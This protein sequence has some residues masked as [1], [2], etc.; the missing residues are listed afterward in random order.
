MPPASTQGISSYA[1]TGFGLSLL[2]GTDYDRRKTKLKEELQLDYKQHI[3]KK[4]ELKTSKPHPQ[5]QGLSLPIKDKTSVQEKLREERNKE[6]NLFLKNQ[7]Q[8]RKFKRVVPPVTKEASD[9]VCISSP[10]SPLQIPNM[11]TNYHPP[12]WERPSSRKDAAT[13][14]EEVGNGKRTGAW[15][16]AQRGRRRWQIIKQR[17]SY[18]SE[19]ELDIDRE[20]ELVIRRIRRHSDTPELKYK[21]ERRAREH[22]ATRAPQGTQEVEASGGHDQ[23]NNAL[24]EKPDLEMP[25]RM[26]AA[27]RSRPATSWDKAE[28]ATG[29]IIGAAEEQTA[30]QLRKEQYKQELLKQ[31]AEQQRN[32]T[33]EK[34][35]QLG[36]AATGVTDPEKEPHR[37]KHFGSENLGYDSWK[38]HSSKQSGIDLKPAKKD[39]YPWTRD[40]IPTEDSEQHVPLGMSHVDQGTALRRLTGT[41]GPRSE[42]KAAQGVPSLDYF[43][44]N[45]HRDFSNILGEVAL[46]RVAAVPPPVTP[47][48][49]SQYK[50]PY[51]AAYY[52]YGAR[53]PLDPHL[54]YYQNGA[55]GGEQQRGNFHSPLQR[56]PPVRPSDCTRAPTPM[57]IGGVLAEKSN[58][59]RENALSY[60]EALRQQIKDREERRK[61]EKEEKERY[62]AKIEAES[63]AYNPWGR[64]GGGAPIKD[65][66]GNLISNL[67]QM[68]RTNKESQRNPVSRNGGHLH[69][70]LMRTVLS[71]GREDRETPPRQLSGFNEDGYREEL[72]KQ[73]EEKRQKQK[74]ESERLRLE[75]EKENK[76]LE[77]ERACIRL[78]YEE[79]QRKQK[80]VEHRLENQ[81]LIHEPKI[82]HKR[83]DRR[84]RQ[85]QEIEKKEPEIEKKEPEIEKNE[86]EIEKNEPE[87]EKKVREEREAAWSYKREPSPPIPTLQRKN[88]NPVPSR[89]PSVVSQLSSGTQPSVS[90]PD[91]REVPAKAPQLQ[92]GQQEVIREL[93]ALRRHL[94]NEQRQLEA[95]TNQTN[96]EKWP[97][98]SH[99]RP[100]GRARADAFEMS[101]RR[102]FQS[103]P[104]SPTPGTACANMQNIREFNQLKYRD[105]A[106]REDLCHMY[107]D[108][109]TDAHSLDIQ[110]QALLREQKRKIRLMGGEHVHDSLDQGMNF[111]H[112]NKPEQYIHRDDILPSQSVFTDVY[113]GGG[114][115]EEQIQK[116]RRQ[117]PAES[118]ERT[119]TRRRRDDIGVAD[120]IDQ[121][122]CQSARGT[123][124]NLEYGN[125]PCEQQHMPRQHTDTG[126]LSGDEADVLSLSSALGRPVSVGTVATEAWLRPG[127]SDAVKQRQ[128]SRM[129]T[130]PWLTK[131][132]T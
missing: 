14:T 62:D 81:S 34:K 82:Q 37:M 129:E 120:P 130:L 21:E 44:E 102:A 49:N 30:S 90:A 68:H 43:N 58:H 29:L 61:R 17:G 47:S 69:G 126:W 70:F 78:K 119:A 123:N 101:Q 66:N 104:R 72:R 111:Y 35:L 132:L 76:R 110:Q 105:T 85:E 52:Y 19:E 59:G 96:S 54:P 117:T 84:A 32:K 9:A 26:R 6:Y 36:V 64:S 53:N 124:K 128:N 40:Q 122:G 24:F 83:E 65:Q 31:I 33:R 99:R 3:A 109:P 48:V 77:N 95:Q 25:D 56:L 94:R 91:F 38:P 28:H 4:K 55:P 114:A 2:L 51:D 41:T 116:Q 10:A 80:K 115:G 50:T 75:E 125:E 107:P 13:L 63:M 18:S 27:A 118:R 98:V 11:P 131:R 67:T 20:Q 92:E 121:R 8:N 42:S 22:R 46:P 93:S 71:P 23:N 73:I 16:P 12:L 108:P 15:I 5:P 89:P 74:E 45:Y 39:L 100:R 7:A 103:A 79:E 127:T 112:P 1:D 57:N 88:R 86:P 97:N 106:S 113:S 60:Q 87:I